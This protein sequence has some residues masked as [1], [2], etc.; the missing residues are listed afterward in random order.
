MRA[1]QRQASE[2]GLWQAHRF[3]DMTPGEI[4]L[5][6]LSFA[7]TKHQQLAQMHASAHL[8]ALAVHSPSLLPQV[9]SPV[10]ENEMTPD[11]MKQR[12]LSWR[13]KE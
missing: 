11:E 1:L 5:V 6:L 4:S 8:L 12:L 3:F 2:Q 13:R 9:P 7:K 10:P